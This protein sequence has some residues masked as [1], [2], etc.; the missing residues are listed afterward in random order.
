M[1]STKP[2]ILLIA[3]T[4]LDKRGQPIKQ[5]RL[6]LPALTLPLLAALTPPEAEV[7]IVSE[8]V[9]PIPYDEPWDLVGLT[10]MGSGII[11]AWEI[12]DEFR[13]RQVKVVLGGIAATLSGPELNLRHADAVVLGEAEESWPQAVHDF[14]AGRPKRVYAAN[15]HAAIADLPVPR[16]ELFNRRSIGFWRPVQATRGC[17]Y[18]CSFCSITSFFQGTYRKRP[19]EQVIRDVRA[20]KRDGSR[21]IAFIDDNIGVDRHYCAALWEALIPERIIWMSQCSLQIAEQPELLR[22]AHRSGCRVLSFGIESVNPASLAGI[23]KSWNHPERYD[24]AI[25]T[26]R[27]HGIEVSTEMMIG[28]DDDDASIFQRTYDFIM[29]NRIAVPRIHILTPI[30]GTRLWDDLQRAGRIV[31]TEFGRYS[32]GSVIF[33]PRHLDPEVLQAEY[34]SLYRRLFSWRGIVHRTLR[35]PAR[36]GPLMRGLVLSVNLHYRD[37]VLRGICPGI[38]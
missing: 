23:N 22:L 1:N 38:V 28:L 30:P 6:H 34:W 13:R 33:R 26:I 14:S 21:H 8:T 10:G 3:P 9:E 5:R 35:N 37:H 12:A 32:G 16:Y 11:R 15:G 29:R 18:T 17:P 24:Q 36:L 31:S 7:R 4:A 2:R 19:I 20:A 25:R 27:A